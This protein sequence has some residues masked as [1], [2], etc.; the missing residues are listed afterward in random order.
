M[1]R[2]VLITAVLALSFIAALGPRAAAQSAP[3]PPSA[4]PVT[5]SLAGTVTGDGGNHLGGVTVT[6]QNQLTGARQRAVTNADGRYELTNLPVEG[7]YQVRVALAGFATSASESVSL[8]PNAVLIVNFRLK[9]TVSESVAVTASPERSVTEVRQTINEQF[10][11]ALPL[12]GRSF[13]PLAMLAAGMTGNPNYPTSQGQPYWANN[14][15]VDGASHFS[16]WR[17][18]ARTFYSGY[19]LESIREVRVLTN[20]FSAEYGETL[21]SVTTAVTRSGSDA[22]HGTGLFFFQNDA[23]SATPEF[24]SVTPPSR[25]ERYGFAMGGPLVRERTQFFES[26]EGR[27]ARNH[28]IV[29]SPERS[30]AGT[31]V[32]DNE[33]EHLLFFRLDHRRSSNEVITARYNGQWF[34]WHNEPAGLTLPGSGTQYRSDVHTFFATDRRSPSTRMHNEARVQFARYIDVRT[35]LDPTVFVSRAGYSE[36]GGTL[37]PYGYGADPED[38]WEGADVVS[39]ALGAHALRIGGGLKYVRAT[40]TFLNFGRGAYFFAGAPGVFTQPTL[41]M[42]GI[43]PSPDFARAD[44]RALAASAFVQDDWRLHPTLTMN[45]GVRYDVERISNVRNYVAGSDVNNVQ[46]RLGAAW[47]PFPADRL[48]VRGGVGVYTQQ[49]LLLYVNRVQL[50]G[51][52]GTVTL[53]LPPDSPIFPAFPT[54]LTSLPAVLPPRDIHRLD[55]SFRNAYSLQASVGAERPVG[56]VTIGADYVVLDGRDLMSLV[57]ANAPA[58]L[59]KPAQRTVAQADAT[60][61]LTPLPGA[62]RNILVLGNEGR[63]WYRALQFKGERTTGQV[64]ALVSY[65]IARVEDIA[66]Y[67][68]PEDSRNIAAEKARANTDVRHNLTVG[69]TWMVP[70]DRA[71]LRGWSVAGIGTFRSNRPYTIVWGDDRNGTTQNDARPGAR[72]TAETGSYRNVDL[73]ILRKVTVRAAAVEARVE[74]FNLFNTTNYDQYVGALLSPFYG[75]PV[76]AFPKRRAQVAAVVKF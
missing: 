44:P 38:T 68:L 9:L 6:V 37:G 73:A 58:S 36:K 54:V 72:N 14:I 41:F 1:R 27:E 74:F 60:R 24:A 28:N 63:S 21:A 64:Q 19:G 30:L 5:G 70:G 35:D 12:V 51:A 75:Q 65:T 52:D 7:E 48:L 10:A 4:A 55:P 40:N 47:T 46:P 29:L 22:F 2:T 67:Q 57:D 50:E 59:V 13:I 8:V 18:A 15:I 56:P 43:A 49:H 53:A 62:F 23:L 26:Y 25:S 71:A 3:P 39:L 61:P 11:H 20:R 32:P 31:F 76:T 42:Q 16:K 17:S 34:R 33:D 45:A 66:N 69:F